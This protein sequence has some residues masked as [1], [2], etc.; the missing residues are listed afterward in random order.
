MS[1]EWV[2]EQYELELGAD[3][4]LRAL[5]SMHDDV[6]VSGL[7]VD[8]GKIDGWLRRAAGESPDDGS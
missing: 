3:A 2:L 6:W 5:A 1:D 8:P 7:H 4:R